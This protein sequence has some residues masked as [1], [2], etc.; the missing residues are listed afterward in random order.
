MPMNLAPQRPPRYGR[1]SFE[2]DEIEYEKKIAQ[3]E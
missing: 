1:N 2:A 3:K